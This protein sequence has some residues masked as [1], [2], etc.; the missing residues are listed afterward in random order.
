MG[1]EVPD[2]LPG[3]P[4]LLDRHEAVNEVTGLPLSEPGVNATDPETLPRVTVPIVGACGT[5]DCTAVADAIDTGPEPSAL[6]ALTVHMY[7]LALVRPVTVFGE[8]ALACE[9]GVPP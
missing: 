1:V 5:V 7:V 2:R 6:V 4:P 3:V 9:P 8:P